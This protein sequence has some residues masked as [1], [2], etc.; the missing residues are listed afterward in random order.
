MRMVWKAQNK[1]SV[2]VEGGTEIM[3]LVILEFEQTMC[4]E[5]SYHTE[6]MLFPKI[7]SQ[8]G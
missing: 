3:S 5:N 7:V 2:Q 1:T 8:F 4:H 6:E